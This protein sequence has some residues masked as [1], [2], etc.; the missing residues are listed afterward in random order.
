[1]W[2]MSV[3]RNGLHCTNC[4]EG[5]RGKALRACMRTGDSLYTGDVYISA[6]MLMLTAALAEQCNV[7]Q[8]TCSSRQGQGCVCACASALD[9]AFSFVWGLRHDAPCCVRT[10]S[11]SAKSGL[12]TV[13]LQCHTL[14]NHRYHFEGRLQI[15]KVPLVKYCLPTLVAVGMHTVYTDHFDILVPLPLHCCCCWLCQIQQMRSSVL[16]TL[17][18]AVV[19]NAI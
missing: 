15:H 19:C 14:C 16:H 5:G 18:L 9:T 3:A 12:F 6:A 1:M 11:C 8:C 17:L 7:L 10:A 2:H 13:F 4:S